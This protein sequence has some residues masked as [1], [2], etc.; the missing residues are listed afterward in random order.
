MKFLYWNLKSNPNL[1]SIIKDCI[2]EN[3]IDIALFSEFNNTNFDK[4]TLI[5][6][7]KYELLKSCGGC[8]KVKVLFRNQIQLSPLLEHQRYLFSTICHLNRKYI[9][10]GVHLPSNTNGNK[11]SDRKNIIRKIINDLAD[12]EN[13]TVSSCIVIGDMN[14]SPFDSEMVEKDAFNAVLFKRLIKRQEVVTFQGD[15]Y[16]RFYNPSIEYITELGENYGSF[17]YGSGNGCLYWYCFDQLLVRKNLVDKI[18]KFKYLKTINEQS[19]LNKSKPNDL[20][21][22]HLPLLVDIEI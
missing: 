14:A 16:K 15:K 22:D 1:E 19:L 20:I 18:T 2:N 3:E 12:N 11:S 7:N 5:L 4:L 8:E 21:S 6:N 13:G 10:V 17:Y 9:L